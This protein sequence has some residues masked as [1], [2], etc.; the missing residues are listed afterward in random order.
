MR[1]KNPR[2]CAFRLDCSDTVTGDAVSSFAFG[3]VSDR[4]SLLVKTRER[5]VHNFFEHP[6]F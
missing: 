3:N 6:N 4:P 5:L 2:R 1:Y